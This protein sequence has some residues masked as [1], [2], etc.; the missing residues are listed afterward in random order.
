MKYRIKQLVPLLL[1][2]IFYALL[3]KG[4]CETR[5]IDQELSLFFVGSKPMIF[6]PGMPFE[7][8]I[9]VR[10]HDQVQST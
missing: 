1:N 10:Y 4:F 7:A 2:I 8:Q 5:I 9:A 6:K 3:Q